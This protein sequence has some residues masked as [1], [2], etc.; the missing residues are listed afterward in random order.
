MWGRRAYAR[1]GKRK[2]LGTHPL[3]II[4]LA[5]W[6]TP[7]HLAVD[8]W[9]REERGDHRKGKIYHFL[10]GGASGSFR[11]GLAH[12]LRDISSSLFVVLYFNFLIFHFLCTKIRPC[13]CFCHF[14]DGLA[15]A[16]NLVGYIQYHGM[17]GR[18]WGS[19]IFHHTGRR[20]VLLPRVPE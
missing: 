8:G 19:F 9:I 12:P 4:T 15:L 5:S 1:N 18:D 14:G 2:A 16:V 3:A 17:E 11:R 6:A 10:S 13:F 20:C 7:S